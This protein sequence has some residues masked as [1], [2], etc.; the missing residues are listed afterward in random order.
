M[1]H[2]G[3][4]EDALRGGQP[5]AGLPEELTARIGENDVGVAATVRVGVPEHIVAVG[6]RDARAI[7]ADEDERVPAGRASGSV[8]A[9]TTRISQFG[10]SAP[11]HHDLTPVTRTVP[12]SALSPRVRSDRGSD[13]ATPGSVMQ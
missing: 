11:V 8:S 4:A 6:E 2:P 9:S 3:R 10:A 12:S 7:A 5:A 1:Q 13:E